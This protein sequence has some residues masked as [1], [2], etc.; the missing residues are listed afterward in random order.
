MD[1]TFNE[2]Q[3][4]LR[5]SVQ[6]FIRNDYS[7]AK[8]RELLSSEPGFSPENWQLFAD[9]G[10]LALPFAEDD[11]GIGGTPVETMIMMEE[12]GKGLVLE[13]YLATVILAGGCIAQAGSAAQKNAL[14]S[15]IIDG[16]SHISLAFAEKQSRYNLNDVATSAGKQGD[17]FIINGEKIVV[18]NGHVAE[19]LIVVARSAGAQ[20]DSHGISLFVVD[21]DAP[22]VSRRSYPTVD[23]LRAAD[24]RLQNVAVRADALLGA[25]GSAYETLDAVIDSG[26]VASAAEAVGIM[27]ALVDATVAYCK[28]REQFGQPIGRFQV[29]QHRM[30]DMF[31]EYEQSKSLLYMAVLKLDSPPDERRKAISALK[32]RIGQG[33]RYIGQQAVQLHGGMGMTDELIIG[34]YFKRLT[35]IS[36]LFGDVDYHLRR[37]A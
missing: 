14:L 37:F 2:E 22:G 26:T 19:K 29:L 13:P 23:G 5:D 20:H 12:F 6:K 28:T 34:H 30:V 33:G 7:F 36:R 11:G 18:L 3:Q 17:Q 10:W 25:A 24:F 21:T 9:L 32:V 1:F 15:G 27:Q 8:R 31:M 4:L 16:S 35:M